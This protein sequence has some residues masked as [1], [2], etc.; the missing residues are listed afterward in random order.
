[1]LEQG[2]PQEERRKAAPGGLKDREAAR[3]FLELV[4]CA[5]FRSAAERLEPSINVVR[6]RRPFD[7][8]LSY[9]PGNV[10]IPKVR[11]MI[12]WLVEAF[13]PVKFPWV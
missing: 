7:I 6:R 1:M 12:D 2:V 8:W 3:V 13:N 9:H 5:S 11:H 4:R 10:R